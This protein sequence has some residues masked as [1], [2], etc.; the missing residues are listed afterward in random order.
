MQQCWAPDPS[1]RPSFT[2]IVELLERLIDKLPRREVLPGVL[3]L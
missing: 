1:K 3:C 2:S